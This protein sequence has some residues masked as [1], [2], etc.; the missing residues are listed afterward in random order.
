MHVK[1]PYENAGVIYVWNPIE[2]QY[3]RAINTDDRYDNLTVEQAKTLKSQYKSSDAHRRT[4]ANGEE[5]IR[6]M[7]ND[8]MRSKTLKERKRGARQAHTTSKSINRD[9]HPTPVSQIDVQKYTFTSDSDEFIEFEVE[10]I[11]TEVHHE[12]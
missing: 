9:Q 6:E 2:N 10:T 7:S 3:F 8:A 12:K 11:N 5:T 1:A 4:R